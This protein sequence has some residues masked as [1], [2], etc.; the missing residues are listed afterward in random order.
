MSYH[1][2]KVLELLQRLNGNIEALRRENKIDEHWTAAD[3][4]DSCPECQKQKGII[5]RAWNQTERKAREKEPL[6]C[7]T[8]GAGVKK[9]EPSCPFCGSKRGHPR[10]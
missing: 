8:C 4:N 7:D 3:I 9:Q 10:E 6:V 5:A 1:Q 2:E